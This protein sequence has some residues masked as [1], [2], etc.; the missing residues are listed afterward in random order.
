MK[1][2]LITL[3]TLCII[4]LSTQAQTPFFSAEQ[5]ESYLRINGSSRTE[6]Q[7][8][9][10]RFS[11]DKVTRNSDDSTFTTIV[12]L[13]QRDYSDFAAMGIPA[14]RIEPLTTKA[15]PVI[16]MATTI[17]EM[18]GYDKYPTYD[19]YT[20]MMAAFQE[21]YPS[22]C[23]IDTILSAT[24]NQHAILVAHLSS[25]L[26]TPSHKPAFWYS[27]SMHG[28]EPVGYFLM[29]HL[30]NYIL[31]HPND[32]L[33]QRILQT[34]DLWISPLENPDGTYRLSNNLIGS[35]YS[36]RANANGYD[37]NRNY[38]AP[39]VEEWVMIQPEIA[40]MMRFA[41]AHPFVMSANLHG[42]AE[43]ANYPWDT[44]RT[45]ER[46]H[47]DARW[48]D[49]ICRQY[50][51]LCQRNN[52]TYMT[53]EGGVTV[54]ADW[55]VITG[56]RQDYMNYYQHCREITLEV[57]N[58]KIAS[59]QQL[60]SLWENSREALLHYI[61]A[62]T[63]GLRGVVTDAQ[64]GEPIAAQIWVNQ[65]DRDHSEVYSHP[66]TG[67]FFRPIA[68]GSYS[69]TISADCYQ[70]ATIDVTVV[71]DSATTLH[72]QLSPIE[73]ITPQLE[74]TT[75]WIG[76]QATF[77][78]EV[79]LRWY[80]TATE[81]QPLFEGDIFITPNLYDT[82]TYW[83][84][85]FYDSCGTEGERRS[86]TVNALHNVGIAHEVRDNRG[87]TLF[88]N[89]TTNHFQ[90]QHEGEG[91]LHLYLHGGRGEL[92]QE[93]MSHDKVIDIDLS[94]YSAGVYTIMIIDSKKQVITQK[95]IKR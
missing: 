8:L 28:D 72:V 43:L 6:V 48:F 55:Y 27:A 88:P 21:Q 93:I 10:H 45:T 49:S 51:T 71:P 60:P 2:Y 82:T 67:N 4:H 74:D 63:N 19:V 17:A 23:Q 54:G 42:G 53:S 92:L 1:R 56:S 62:C 50:V 36:G 73:A 57:S 81:T 84:A 15:R 26:D 34:V 52:N 59:S 75:I 83:Y 13:H 69:I 25:S 7:Q 77:S 18:S 46:A 87:Y 90:L 11:V 40:A 95:V 14:H 68:T 80:A 89:P 12:W 61:L 35:F 91:L 66:A 94:N 65:H 20:Q 79:P 86:V 16:N 31:Q 76:S 70:P 33:V 44:W 22:I 5:P 9:A 41:D 78:S 29:L 47:P 38:P 37:L 39:T 3:L 85:A 58:D 30:I 32:S 24:P 64:T